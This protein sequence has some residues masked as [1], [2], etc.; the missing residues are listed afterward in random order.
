MPAALNQPG[1]GRTSG[2]A[3]LTVAALAEGMTGP[4]RAH[5]ES[6]SDVLAAAGHVL[7]IIKGGEGDLVSGARLQHD[8][9]AKA[10][11]QRDGRGLP[12]HEQK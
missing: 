4:S 9:D 6:P 2:G 8:G 1:G 11:G 3:L 12:K 10:R 7:G 5:R